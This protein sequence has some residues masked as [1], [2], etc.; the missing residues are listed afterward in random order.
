M[1]KRMAPKMHDFAETSDTSVKSLKEATCNND[2]TL[3]RHL[4]RSSFE[5]M[6]QTK[7]KTSEQKRDTSKTHHKNRPYLRYFDVERAMNSI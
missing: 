4:L 5:D 3:L 1:I 2:K 7:V 6:E